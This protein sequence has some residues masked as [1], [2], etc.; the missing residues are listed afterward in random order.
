MTLGTSLG[1]LLA[2]VRVPVLFTEKRI[3]IPRCP[4]VFGRHLDNREVA[5]EVP[6][7]PKIKTDYD[8]VRTKAFSRAMVLETL[9]IHCS[10]D[11]IVKMIGNL[12]P[13]TIYV[14]PTPWTFSLRISYGR[15]ALFVG[16]KTS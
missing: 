14:F 1:L 16:R 10:S 4:S 2:F 15:R 5:S 13:E 12:G 6:N 7:V 8:L 9:Q 3:D 11:A